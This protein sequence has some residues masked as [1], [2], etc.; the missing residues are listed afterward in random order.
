MDQLARTMDRSFFLP[1][2]AQ[3]KKTGK[4]MDAPYAGIIL[5]M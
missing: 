5:F 4:K 1:V 2:Q 3:K